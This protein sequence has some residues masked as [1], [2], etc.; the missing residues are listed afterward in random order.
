M[1]KLFPPIVEGT[2]PAFYSN[3]MVNITIPFSMNKAVNKNN[4]NGIAVKAKTLQ[5]SSYLFV[6]TTGNFSLDG[7]SYVTISVSSEYFKVGQFYKFQIAYIDLNNEIGY[8]SNVTI[9]K[10]TSNPSVSIEGLQE[11]KANNHIYNYFGVYKNSDLTESVYSYK[12]DLY[13]SKNEIILSSGDLIHNGSNDDNIEESIDNFLIS[14]DLNNEIYYLQYSVTTVNN[15]KLKTNK[16]SIKQSIS[17][18]TD[19][20]NPILLATMDSREKENGLVKISLKSE[21]IKEINGNF[22]LY[23][24]NEDSNY[25]DWEECYR[26]SLNTNNI[27][28]DNLWED[29]TVQCGKKYKYA[30]CQYNDNGMYSE[31]VYTKEPIEIEF[32]DSFLG[33]CN[34]QLKIRFNPK[35]SSFKNNNLETK[36]ETIG[37]K[38]PFIFRNGK[39][40]YKE[41]PISGLISYLMDKDNTFINNNFSFNNQIQRNYKNNNEE[42]I[43]LENNSN[44]DLTFENIIKEKNF[45]NEVLDWLT[46]GK[47]KI[48]RSPTE[49]NFIVR[50]MN[51]S[52]TPLDNLGRM[53]HS[54]NCTAY[55]VA[56][57]NYEN[58]KAFNLI[59][60]NS[61]NRIEQLQWK[62][63]SL[64]SIDY[65]IISQGFS[66]NLIDKT[67]VS[68]RFYDMTPGDIIKV[69]F[70]DGNTQIIQ[71]GTTGQYMLENANYN[72][73]GVYLGNTVSK[74]LFTYGYYQIIINDF[75]TYSN[76]DVIEIPLQQFIGFNKNIFEDILFVNG[77][78]NPKLDIVKIPI[79]KAIRRPIE[80]IRREI[81]EE[82]EVKYFM[83]DGKEEIQIT[84]FNPL[85]LYSIYEKDKDN[86]LKYCG[87]FS[88]KIDYDK[89]IDKLY[90]KCQEE[91]DTDYNFSIICGDQYIDIKDNYDYFNINNPLEMFYNKNND[92]VI[93]VG[94]GVILEITYIMKSADFLI[95]EKEVYQVK[96][97]REKFF[98]KK[99]ELNK[100]YLKEIDDNDDIGHN[101]HN[102]E[103]FNKN[104]EVRDSYNNYIMMLLKEIDRQSL[105]EGTVDEYQKLC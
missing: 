57:Y 65:P 11:G 12:F 105:V 56:E 30:I 72:I 36:I 74:G 61:L 46:D 103:I 15:L 42:S 53:L 27:N 10:Y 4:I 77:K 33:D 88:F 60:L 100:L 98:I 24:S 99:D 3:G 9:G 80:E 49:G 51:V 90:W 85:V 40:S 32:E 84:E 76:L 5:S 58:L 75:S 47:P 62:T 19:I 7:E 44:T 22:I 63:L 52:L 50:L 45:K 82:N 25:L 29:K 87:D 28:I 14:R 35:I 95:E 92:L 31:K 73:I 43:N 34:R 70:N 78:R 71:I 23:R 6:N 66:K 59:K 67:V 89:E 97:E 37:S 41:F 8:Y 20:V 94:K 93:S 102:I 2:I 48:F 68:I 39:V 96:E 55:E 64:N 13:N 101:K 21:T 38:H 17:I 26:F 81:N 54:F 83:Y 79:I 91:K 1:A 69:V 86:K 18:D 104:I 16:Y